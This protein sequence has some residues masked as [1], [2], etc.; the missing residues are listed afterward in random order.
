MFNRFSVNAI[1]KGAIGLLAGALIVFLGAGVWTSWQR[2]Q[3]ATRTATVADASANL[4]V[5]LNNLR[6]DGAFTGFALRADATGDVGKVALAARAEEMPALRNA[7]DLLVRLDL[8]ATML[9]DLRN[10]VEQMKAIDAEADAAKRQPKSER[11]AGL[12]G[13][14][15]KTASALIAQ[16]EKVSAHLAQSIKLDDAYVDQL[17]ALKGFAWN[18]R[19][20]GGQ[21][22]RM[23]AESFLKKPKPEAAQTYAILRARLGEALTAF[24]Q[25]AA[26]L[27]L[28]ADF[29]DG[30]QKI[31]TGFFS[32]E[33]A[34]NQLR[35]LT[36]NIA[37]QDPGITQSELDKNSIA[38]LND[39]AI[40]AKRAMTV[41][42]DHA[43]RIE[44]SAR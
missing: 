1:L 17:L 5:A 28:P 23:V 38:S 25:L 13:D 32:D 27:P 36:A 19:S 42:Q 26:G 29:L 37:G 39:V 20:L 43:A 10:G 34:R 11:R 16:V 22:S 4:F 18:M 31:K 30:V 3:T 14:V 8:P 7:L 21:I 40:V 35:V 9:N 24:E 12:I 44:S 6:M 15:D 2:V 41:A 33:F